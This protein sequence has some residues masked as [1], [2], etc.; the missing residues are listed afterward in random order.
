MSDSLF[1]V[2]KG[3][4]LQETI[5]NLLRDKKPK[6]SSQLSEEERKQALLNAEYFKA[7]D[8]IENKYEPTIH[9]IE[10]HWGTGQSTT[11]LAAIGFGVY[12]FFTSEEISPSGRYKE[13]TLAKELKGKLEYYKSHIS[14][15]DMVKRLGRIQEE[16]EVGI[17]ELEQDPS[18]QYALSH[19][20]D[21]IWVLGACVIGVV[22]ICSVLQKLKNIHKRKFSNM[23]LQERLQ[24]DAEYKKKGLVL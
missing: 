11:V 9:K 3:N 13:Y 8:N 10:K 24:V 5:K 7:I 19:Q 15:E 21:L 23:E 12:K 6:E 20:N 14:S 2:R 16:T 18:V 22:G 1:P 17:Q 4:D